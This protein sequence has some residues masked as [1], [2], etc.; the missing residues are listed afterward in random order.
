MECVLYE[1]GPIHFDSHHTPKKTLNDIDTIFQ[2][3]SAGAIE[4][5][6]FGP[7]KMLS[8][9]ELFFVQVCCPV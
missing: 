9:F 2:I 6:V 7:K 1:G 8:L 5:K 4:E 3:C